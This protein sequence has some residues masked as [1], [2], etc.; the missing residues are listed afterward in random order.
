M[1]AAAPEELCCLGMSACWVRPVAMSYTMGTIML[2]GSWGT[3]MRWVSCNCDPKQT[4]H[5]ESSIVYMYQIMLL[6]YTI[7]VLSGELMVR[8]C[9][10]LRRTASWTWAPQ[11]WFQEGRLGEHWGGWWDR[12]GHSTSAVQPGQGTE[13]KGKF[14]L[15]HVFQTQLFIYK[16]KEIINILAETVIKDTTYTSQWKHV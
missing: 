2:T 15:C 5:I 1:S 4:K 7:C 11:R 9:R 10:D 13:E 6:R 3:G 16:I 8:L 14:L 12:T